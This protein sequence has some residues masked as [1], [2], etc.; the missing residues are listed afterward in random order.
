MLGLPELAKTLRELRA[1]LPRSL[2]LVDPYILGDPLETGKQ[3]HDHLEIIELLKAIET[4]KTETDRQDAEE[5]SRDD[6]LIE[7]DVAQIANLVKRASKP[8]DS[9]DP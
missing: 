3:P 9:T 6:H 5:T 1:A 8:T 2:G 7:R 4:H